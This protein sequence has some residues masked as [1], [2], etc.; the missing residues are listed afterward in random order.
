M[1]F[2]CHCCSRTPHG[3]GEWTKR[4]PSWNSKAMTATVRS[5]RSRQFAT[6]RYMP[7]SQKATYQAY[8]TWCHRRTTRKRKIP[9]SQHRSSNTSGRS[10]APSIRSTR[11]SR[12]LLPSQPIPLHQRHGPQSS[13]Q[14]SLSQSLKQPN[15]SEA[16]LQKPVTL[17]NEQKKAEL[18]IFTSALALDDLP[19]I[20]SFSP[21]LL[22]QFLHF[23]VLS[24]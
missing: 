1:F 4:H 8:T 17:T 7:G 15:K 6:V 3:R 11:R 13:Q 14:P 16:G 21:A 18:S 22:F 2:T 5:T 12:Q 20:C 23:S 9:R 24:S 10:S 19:T